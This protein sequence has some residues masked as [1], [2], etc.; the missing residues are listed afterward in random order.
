[1]RA[2]VDE[3]RPVWKARFGVELRCGAGVNTA[4]VVAGNI[5]SSRKTNYTVLGDGVNLASRL[6]GANKTYGTEILVGDGTRAA[7]GSEFAFRALDLLRVKGKH[8]EIAVFELVGR[9]VDLDL[10]TRTWLAGW[11]DAMLDYRSR[12]FAEARAGFAEALAVRSHDQ[13]AREY[14]GR[15]ETLL[16]NPP[17]E[18]WSP[19]F[20]LHD[21]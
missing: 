21:K 8:N 19:I 18:D 13:A 11:D 17:P 6:E 1:M 4:P 9:T 2:Q 10:A 5:G 3:L 16:E 20:E 14:L 12:R 7:A 15:C